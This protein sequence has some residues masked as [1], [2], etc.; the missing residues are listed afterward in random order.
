MT[1]KTFKA[2][3]LAT[4][5]AL[6]CAIPLLFTPRFSSRPLQAQGYSGAMPNLITPATGLVVTYTAGSVTS[7]GLVTAILTGTVTVS[8]AKTD[9]SAPGYATCNFVYWNT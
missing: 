8:D 5:L 1:M 9:C 2:I 3:A 7:G 4:T 6:V